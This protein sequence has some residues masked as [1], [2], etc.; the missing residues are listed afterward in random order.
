MQDEVPG[1]ADEAFAYSKPAAAFGDSPPE[2]PG[3]QALSE[4]EEI[5]PGGEAA[6]RC[7]S[8]AHPAPARREGG[9]TLCYGLD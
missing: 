7:A 2:P 6:T 1:L 8:P 5:R 3:A 9:A 4:A